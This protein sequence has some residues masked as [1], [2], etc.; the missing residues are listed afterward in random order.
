MSWVTWVS[1]AV[2]VV[3]TLLV[4][5]DELYGPKDDILYLWTIPV[6]L[7]TVIALCVLVHRVLRRLHRRDWTSGT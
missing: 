3:G 6:I 1:I 4:V 2:I 5:Y 7:L